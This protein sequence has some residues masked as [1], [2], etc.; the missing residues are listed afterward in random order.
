[1]KM[2]AP[3][4]DQLKRASRHVY[5]EVQMLVDTANALQVRT[6][7]KLTEN[8]LLESFGV[9]ARALLDFLDRTQSTQDDVY[10]ALYFQPPKVWTQPTFSAVLNPVREDVNKQFAH[11]TFT[12]LNYDPPHEKQW[13]VGP[14]ASE[15]CALIEA[16]FRSKVDPALLD[17][18][19]KGGCPMPM[20][21][22]RDKTV[23]TGIR[24]ELASS[25]DARF[26][27]TAVLTFIS[28]KDEPP[29]A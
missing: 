1:M 21:D 15:I 16:L 18:R 13:A 6:I 28:S 25:T 20:R 9:H 19:W 27:T 29:K 5:Y 17:E 24:A 10:A 22:G 2:A 23:A 26:S 14:I 12:R 3:T 7:D 4:P 11:I 8:A